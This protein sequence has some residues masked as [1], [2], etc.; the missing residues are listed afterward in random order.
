MHATTLTETGAAQPATRAWTPPVFNTW[1]AHRR[2]VVR[3]ASAVY[4]LLIFEGVLR[5]WIF[6]QYSRPLFFVRDPIVLSIYILV[7]AKRTKLWPSRF[8]EIG[9]AFAV[10]GLALIAIQLAEASRLPSYF[11]AYGWRN[12]FF[13]MPLACIAARY[14]TLWDLAKLARATLIAVIPMTVLVVIQLNAGPHAP[15]N[16]GLGGPNDEFIVHTSEYGVV[17]PAGTFTSDQG[18]SAFSASALAMSLAFWVLPQ[19]SRPVGRLLLLTAT[20]CNLICIGLSG[21]RGVLLWAIVIVGGAFIGLFFVRPMLHFRA[22]LLL[23]PLLVVGAISLP[24]LFPRP[25]TAFIARWQEAGEA[26]S[27]AY[28]GGGILARFAYESTLFRLLAVNTPASGYGIGSAGNAAWQMG[29]RNDVIF[30]R[31]QDEVNAAETDWGRNIL[32]LGPVLGSLFILFRVSFVAT[33]LWQGL[34]ATRNTGHSFPWLLALYVSVILAFWQITG[35]GTLNGYGWLFV[36]F[37]LAAIQ[38]ARRF[39]GASA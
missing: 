11:L 25:T 8:L 33:L 39:Q 26:E 15:V 38:Q 16:S 24:I 27:H 21:S 23:V 4:W 2:L 1:E 17:R 19:R 20:G 9:L 36:G 7:L 5:K 13:Y 22:T 6:P 10:A 31:N 3:L 30:F 14:F 37:T 29:V 34:A 28:G 35:N 32:E 12:Y 18:L